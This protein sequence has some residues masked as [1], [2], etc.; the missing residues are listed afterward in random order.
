MMHGPG[1]I[2]FSKGDIFEGEWFFNKVLTGNYYDEK[3][4][5]KNIVKELNIDFPPIRS[6]ANYNGSVINNLREG[7]G[8][9]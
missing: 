1:R 4:K 3:Q 7:F 9:Y 2:I 6:Q 8:R 5:L